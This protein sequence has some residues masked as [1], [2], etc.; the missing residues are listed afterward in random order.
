SDEGN[1]EGSNILNIHF[2][3]D[4]AAKALKME[5]DEVRSILERGRAKLF[6]DREK[7]VKPFRDEKVLTAWNGLMLAAFAE[8]A[9]VLDNSE[10][11][12]IARKNADF[13]LDDL[14]D[15]GRLLRTWKDGKAKLNGY[16]GDYANFADG[17]F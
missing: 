11:L 8:A 3:V 6:A 15:D 12:E 2:T 9:A 17:L 4:A 16:I 1:F 5:V 7:R 13:I 14:H 10:Y